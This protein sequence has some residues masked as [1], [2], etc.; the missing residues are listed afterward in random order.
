MNDFLRYAAG[1]QPQ[2]N[3]RAATAIVGGIALLCSVAT[4]Y[5]GD[6]SVSEKPK[7]DEAVA[8]LAGGCFWCTEAVFERMEGVHDVV[9]GYIGGREPNPTYEMVCSKMTGH[10]EA[11]EIHYDP[12]KVKFEELLQVFFKTHDPTTLNRQGAD[13]GPQYR[14]SI[15]FHND[16]QKQIAESY[17]AQLDASGKFPGPI[18]TKLEEATKFYVA[19]EYHQDY[20]RLNPNAGYCQA[21]VRSKVEKFDREFADKR[22][23]SVK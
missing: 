10:A 5:P 12:A 2:M 18:V 23:A 7:P 20:Y 8:T 17:I 9:S 21:V 6:E 4:A 16:D 14:S 22:K 1:I 13:A 19:E 3:R 11:V 15:F